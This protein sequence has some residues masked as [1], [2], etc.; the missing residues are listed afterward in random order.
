MRM[1]IVLESVCNIRK[2]CA[3]ETGIRGWLIE[4]A[5]ISMKIV[6]TVFQTEH[7]TYIIR[8]TFEHEYW[9]LD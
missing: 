1:W 7:V 4:S 9:S 8:I 5:T 3:P 6:G 2:I